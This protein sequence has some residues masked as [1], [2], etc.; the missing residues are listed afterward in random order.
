[1]KKTN[2]R[3]SQTVKKILRHAYQC[4]EEGSAS[5]HIIDACLY[6]A[7][8]FHLNEKGEDPKDLIER[9]L[10]YWTDIQDLLKKGA[11]NSNSY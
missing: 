9:L 7:I 3:H 1:M 2:L 11:L 4:S 8:I 10:K 5:H 6:T